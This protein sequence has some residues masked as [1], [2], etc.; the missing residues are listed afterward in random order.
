MES[1]RNNKYKLGSCLAVALLLGGCNARVATAPEPK[2]TKMPASG[3]SHSDLDAA[4]YDGRGNTTCKQL[5]E[6]GKQVCLPSFTRL[7]AMPDRYHKMQLSLTGVVVERA[8]NLYLYRDP[9]S[10]ELDQYREAVMLHDSGDDK[11][12][13]VRTELRED[14]LCAAAVD[15]EFDSSQ[16]GLQ[17]LT[18]TLTSISRVE[19][20]HCDP[21]PGGM[22]NE[23]P[24]R[25]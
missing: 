1:V 23:R 12:D 2:V 13:T 11:L 18:G 21:V 4:T 22:K 14:R 15:G 19:L 3:G 17:N 20:I 6:V 7:V 16:G 10:A 8:G 9:V 24:R 25:I 5:Y